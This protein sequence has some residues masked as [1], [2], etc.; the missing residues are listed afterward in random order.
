MLI[1]L[2]VMRLTRVGYQVL[3]IIALAAVLKTLV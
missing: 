2:H 3:A 1:W